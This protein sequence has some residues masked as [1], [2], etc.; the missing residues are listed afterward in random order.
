MFTIDRPINDIPEWGVEGTCDHR[1]EFCNTTC[2]N[3]KLYRI[4]PDMIPAD[5]VRERWWQQDRQEEVA[6]ILARKRSKQTSRA[7]M[8]SR[9]EPFKG[10]RDIDRVKRLAAATPDT[11]WWVP[12]RAWRDPILRALIDSEIRPLPNV[13]VLASM[14]PSNTPEEWADIKMLGWSTMFYGDDD[15]LVSPNGDRMFKCPKTWGHV[16]GAC[17]VCKNGCFKELVKG[18]RVDVHLSRH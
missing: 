5:V 11:Q 4:F 14:D 15:M 18:E 16:E 6:D 1:T 7:R 10:M 3:I 17:A 12:T 13:V 8:C 9:G 2:Y